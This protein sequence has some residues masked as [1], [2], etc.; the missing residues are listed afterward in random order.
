MN[1]MRNIT[2]MG[3]CA[4]VE[5][6]VDFHIS[7][8]TLQWPH[9]E[10]DG[11]S[12]HRRLHCLLNCLMR[13]RS[14]KM[15]KLRVTGLC[16]GDLQVAGELSEQKASNKEKDSIWWRHHV[17]RQTIT[18][19]GAVAIYIYPPET[20]LKHKFPEIPL[21]CDIYFRFWFSISEI[22]YWKTF[23][24]ILPCLLEGSLVYNSF[25]FLI[26]TS[27]AMDYLRLK[28]LWLDS[29]SIDIELF[30]KRCFYLMKKAKRFARY[31][32]KCYVTNSYYNTVYY[33]HNKLLYIAL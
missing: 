29:I 19:L 30:M 4:L 10:R 11:V 7:K 14:K 28:K 15:S 20:H 6:R 32:I 22:N 8:V 12:S 24:T 3:V 25:Q 27:N 5:S 31:F 13:H 2:F 18:S 33:I 17:L 21:V 16:E 23:R 26:S 9:N 1:V